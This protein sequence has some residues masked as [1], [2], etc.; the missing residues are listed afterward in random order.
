M[1]FLIINLGSRG[2]PGKYTC[3]RN[4]KFTYWDRYLERVVERVRFARMTAPEHRREIDFERCHFFKNSRNKLY[5]VGWEFSRLPRARYLAKISPAWK[6]VNSADLISNSSRL[7]NYNVKL[8]H[9]PIIERKKKPRTRWA[10]IGPCTTSLGSSDFSDWDQL[11]TRLYPAT[12]I[13]LRS[14]DL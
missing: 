6:E 14:R 7:K 10:K 4:M 13:C 5:W 1:F 2:G 11:V 9:M 8:S 3:R 12:M